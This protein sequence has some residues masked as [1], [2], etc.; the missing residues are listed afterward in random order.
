M[1]V[2]T[3]SLSNLSRGALSVFQVIVG[4]SR[5]MHAAV[6]SSTNVLSLMGQRSLTIVLFTID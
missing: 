6:F 5:D 3:Q 4:N 2:E 1:L